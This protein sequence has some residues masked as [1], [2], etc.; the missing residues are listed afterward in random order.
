MDLAKELNDALFKM[1]S[2]PGHPCA[3]IAFKGEKLEDDSECD[4]GGMCKESL[5]QWFR[6]ELD[7]LLC[8]RE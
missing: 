7:H 5:E 4:M 3:R 6:K 2:D 8:D 1:G